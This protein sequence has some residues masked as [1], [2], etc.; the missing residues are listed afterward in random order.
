VPARSSGPRPSV[1]DLR[2]LAGAF[3]AAR[4]VPIHTAAAESYPA[5]FEGVERHGDGEWWRV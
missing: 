5:L 3:D 4:V 2:R 1:G